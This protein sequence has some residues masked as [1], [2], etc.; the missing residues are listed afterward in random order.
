MMVSKKYDL[1][2][3]GL[4]LRHIEMSKVAAA[5]REGHDFN[6][7]HDI[8]GGKLSTTKKFLNE[9]NKR[10]EPL[11]GKQL[12]LL[13]DGDLQ[14]QK[15]IAFLAICKAHS[16]IRDFVVEVLREK[17]LVFDYQLSEG[18]YI[19]FLR[20]KEDLYP[21]MEELTETTKKKVKQVTFKMLEQ[22]GLIDDVKSKM[23]QVQ[24]LDDVL[25]EAI[26]SDDPNW[27]KVF[28]MSDT[29]IANV[30]SI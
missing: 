21:E 29:D 30:N 16:F 9:I 12:D 4:S 23:I 3:T 26:A 13:I 11:T 22:A 20:R 8:G 6:A 1:S 24:L 15:Q 25:I 27:L 28:L 10:L 7:I 18:E 17:F 19:S 5:K 14:S 2:F